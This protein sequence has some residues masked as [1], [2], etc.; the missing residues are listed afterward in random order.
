MLESKVESFLARHSFSLEN[1]RIVVGVSGGP[2][3]LALLHY[4]LN[5]KEKRNLFLVVSHVDHMFRGEESYRD[6]MFVKD[7][8]MSNNIPFEMVQVN[9]TKIMEE[10]GK[11]SQIAAREVRYDFY[12]KVMEQYQAPY[13][14]L[15]HHGDD[16]VETMLM[17][18]TRG[19]SGK[20]RAGIPFARS[21]YEGIIF[22]PFL[23]LTKDELQNYCERHKLIPRIDPSNEKGIYSRNRFRKHVLPFLKTENSHV[24]QHFQRF[25]EDLQSD[26]EFLLELTIER[27]NTVLTKRE[28]GKIT[29]DIKQFLAMPL[30][31]QRRG[32]QLIL[33]YLYKEKPA[34]LSAIHIDQIFSLIHHHEPSGI[35]DLPNGLKVIRSYLQ[36]SFQYEQISAKPYYFEI[37]SPGTIMLPNGGSLTI[38]FIAGENLDVKGNNAIFNADQIHFPLI[39]R[40]RKKGDRMTLKGIQGSKKLKDIF[41]DQKVP[42]EERELWPVITDGEGFIIWIPNIK[43]SSLEG[44]DPTAEQYILLTYNK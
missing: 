44:I 31:L 32:I 2:D 12:H 28:E 22:R 15:G 29:I 27:L 13:L 3:S 8:C 37:N 25:S 10:T 5:E 21:F 18:L 24:H 1:K 23:C 38:D 6:A 36:L 34:S 19:S 20:A 35:L 14:A 26:E 40:S 16:Q 43:R 33:N 39:I 9:V 30:P 11:S 41:I 17:R 42:R 7:F 4:L